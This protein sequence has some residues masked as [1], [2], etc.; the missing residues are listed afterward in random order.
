MLDLKLLMNLSNIKH[1]A[2]GMPIVKENDTSNTEM[3]VLLSGKLN[4][5]KNYGQTNQVTVSTI[6]PGNMFGEMSLFAKMPRSATVVPI[7]D[8][9]VLAINKINF[10]ELSSKHPELIFSIC[11]M[12]ANRIVKTND[13]YMNALNKAKNSVSAIFPAGHG[14]YPG[15]VPDEY[16]NFTFEV[17][18]N[19]LACGKEIMIKQPVESK[20]K[21]AKP[22]GGDM[23][24]YFEGF[25]PILFDIAVCPHCYF[26]TMYEYFSKPQI[27][28]DRGIEDVLSGV[29]R[30][31][32]LNFDVYDYNYVL[33]AYYIA[34]QCAPSFVNQKQLTSKLWM[35]LTWIYGDLGDEKMELYAAEKAFESYQSLYLESSGLKPDTE[36]GICMILGHL[37]VML[38]KL[39]EA[40]RFYNIVR[41]VKA[42]SPVYKK[43]AEDEIQDMR[44]K[45]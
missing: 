22:I 15:L 31:I 7:V 34:L 25:E 21:S 38:G 9:A 41:S 19:C 33:A 32:T 4:V 23:R 17:K 39:N 24:R 28:R 20:L 2:A 3:Y 43:L 18:R 29:R 5:V 11:E 10:L 40:M 37:C 27:F 1:F 6:E 35:N 12:M 42:G 30:D 14:D 44:A 16:M 26:A 36:Q 45:G 13:A 8:A